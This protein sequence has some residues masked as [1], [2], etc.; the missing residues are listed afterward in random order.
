[1]TVPLVLI[2]S[3]FFQLQKGLTEEVQRR[4]EMQKAAEEA[5]RNA[6]A[7][8][9]AKSRFLANM[10]HGKLHLIILHPSL[11]SPVFILNYLAIN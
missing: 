1:M 2:S 7:A 3:L 11:F 4:K 8:E 6:E 9:A 5:Q 10:S